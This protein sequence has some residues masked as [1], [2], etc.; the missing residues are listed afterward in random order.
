MP[1]HIL[2]WIVIAIWCLAGGAVIRLARTL[3]LGSVVATVSALAAGR[4]R[5]VEDGAKLGLVRV[6]FRADP[7]ELLEDLVVAGPLFLDEFPELGVLRRK[8]VPVVQRL[9]ERR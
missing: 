4:R 8:N 7:L 5:A 1:N 9:L 6:A 2:A 3:L